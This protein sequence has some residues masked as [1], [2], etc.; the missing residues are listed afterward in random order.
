MKTLQLFQ[1]PDP[2]TSTWT[3]MDGTRYN[4]GRRKVLGVCTAGWPIVGIAPGYTVAIDKDGCQRMRGTAEVFDRSSDTFARKMHGEW[5]GWRRDE[6]G[7][8]RPDPAVAAM[9]A[10]HAGEQEQ[11]DHWRYCPAH[12]RAF[13]SDWATRLLSGE[14]VKDLLLT[15][16]YRSGKTSTLRALNRELRLMDQQCTPLLMPV[17]D[18]ALVQAD[19]ERGN[20]QQRDLAVTYWQQMRAAPVLLLDDLTAGFTFDVAGSNKRMV[21]AESW[22]K[23]EA[24]LDERHA[25][26]LPVIVADNL[27]LAAM[28]KAGL[29]QRLAWRMRDW[30][31][32]GFARN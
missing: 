28:V 4:V 19:G 9:L 7:D 27:D 11:A 22:A 26:R 5:R 13:L 2:C 12:I 30:T 16:T 15:G 18:L 20:W 1:T 10:M 14:S 3:G 29:P 25:N 32:M 6:F 24:T 8:W 21:H 31:A 23:L 17:K